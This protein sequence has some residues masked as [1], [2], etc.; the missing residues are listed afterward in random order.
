M[1]W[2]HHLKISLKF[3][4]CFALVL[5]ILLATG[6]L[7][8][9]NSHKINNNLVD[10]YENKL[11]TIKDLGEI[12]SSFHRINTHL[13]NY[14]L[15]ANLDER[16]KSKEKMMEN[17]KHIDLLL[18]NMALRPLPEE[19]VKELELF[20]GLWVNYSEKGNKV[21]ELAD[22]NQKASAQLIYEK[23]MLNKV[24]G[25]DQTFHNFI[26]LNKEEAE[27]SYLSSSAMYK[28]VTAI[29][30]GF[31]AGSFL[32]SIALGY[33][34]TSSMVNPIKELLRKFQLM[35]SGDLSAPISIQRK[36][37]L[38]QLAL[39]SEQMRQ[40][41][42][43]II[44]QAQNSVSTLSDVSDKIK[45][46]AILTGNSSQFILQGL[47]HST[48]RF[49][50][51][52]EMVSGDAAIV[53]EMSMGL[54]QMAGDVDQMNRH[55]LDMETV[56][57]QGD[58]AVRDAIDKMNGLQQQ[59]MQSTESVRNLAQLSKDINQVITT[60]MEI[61]EETNLLALNASIEAARAGEAGLGFAVVASEVRK[62]AENSRS[63]ADRVRMDIGKMQA[64]TLTVVNSIQ[65]WAAEI[66]D[67]QEKVENVSLAFQ[68]IRDWVYKMNSSIQE[69]SANIE[70]LAAGSYQIDQ[71]MRRIEN[72]SVEVSDSTES[73]ANTSGEQVKSMNEVIV[74]IESILAISE[75]LNKAT[76]RFTVSPQG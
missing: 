29:S 5:I 60:I 41:I 75:E 56:S 3:M 43:S 18:E 12:S 20:K 69:V 65:I 52:S 64:G 67:G 58:V 28:K 73:Y 13:G 42:A 51:Q 70:E 72:F 19:Y 59:V 7:G 22:Q 23:E 4:V 68:N 36:D 6:V 2:F 14:L 21:T 32:I 48:E 11:I 54:Q 53:K 55:A 71:S 15:T 39:A 40:S 61:A 76:S 50:H 49:K 66:L 74:S 44:N 8:M 9:T 27:Q 45:Q 33:I 16:I 34:I 30:I 24:E 38:G 25:I 37:E 57:A 35:G 47:Q 1:S 17:Q 31:I 62:L 63:A 46:S 26:E 10:I